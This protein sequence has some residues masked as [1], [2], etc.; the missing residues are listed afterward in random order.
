MPF[1]SENGYYNVFAFPRPK[2]VAFLIDPNNCSPEKLDAIIEFNIENYGG[3]YN[4]IIPVQDNKIKNNYWQLLK[5]SDPDIVYSYVKLDNQLIDKIDKEISPY[6]FLYHRKID[7]MANDNYTWHVDIDDLIKTMDVFSAMIKQKCADPFE[8]NTI[9]SFE[10]FENKNID[11]F[12]SRNFGVVKH[13]FLKAKVQEGNILKLCKDCSLSH[14]LK[15]I[16]EKRGI[17]T[18][19]QASGFEVNSNEPDYN[20]ENEYNYIII[21]D[22]IWSWLYYWNRIIYFPAWKR[23]HISQL[24]IPLN[25]FENSENKKILSDFITAK[26]WSA[27]SG[28]STIK[29]ISSVTDE[30]SLEIFAKEITKGHNVQYKVEK[31]D[32]NTF[33]VINMRKL[34]YDIL[35]SER[36]HLNGSKS[37]MQNTYPKNCNKESIVGSWMIDLKIEYRPELFSYINH[38]YW[39]KLPKHSGVTYSFVKQGGRITS[40]GLISI[41][42]G[43]DKKHIELQIPS[44]KSVFYS[45]LLK[46]RI[47]MFTNDIRQN[48]LKEERKTNNSKT[49]RISDKGA[50]TR[51]VMSIFPNLWM[52]KEFIG[53]RYWRK[54][55]FKMCQ[56]VEGDNRNIKPIL[57]KIDKYDSNIW[58]KLENKDNNAKIQ[59]AEYILKTSKEQQAVNAKI[60]FDDLLEY[61][62]KEREEFIKMVGNSGFDVT[63]ENNKIDLLNAVNELIE[64]SVFEQG[65]NI[66]CKYCG[67]TIWYGL[68]EFKKEVI[69]HGCQTS[70]MINAESK[71]IYKLNELIKNGIIFHGVMPVIWTLGELLQ[72][73]RDSFIYL[74][75]LK[76]YDGENKAPSMEIDIVCIKDG[77][78]VIGEVKTSVNNFSEKEIDKLVNICKEIRPN[79]VVV[80]AFKDPDKKINKI[81][82]N[83]EIKLKGFDIKVIAI[84][85]GNS[86]FSPSYHI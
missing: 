53:N 42:T 38:S 62:N 2:R 20:I 17:I 82:E 24:C 36:Y 79:E 35:Y 3:R 28:I 12:I 29:F 40:D 48:I 34:N 4:P 45:Y 56:I 63:K 61:F 46:D 60:S 22:D 37:V 6:Y 9:L 76:I 67:S 64:I 33:P 70:N 25:D 54:I 8:N 44:D 41:E 14:I 39:W 43:S 16:S 86:Y 68:E 49:I 57:E 15:L 84:I 71:W 59:L 26:F 47:V 77:K 75:S 69:C 1:N 30:N 31:I 65:V 7:D 80:S 51:G 72:F 32:D 66:N 58:K 83:V 5:I 85:P 81:R 52:L 23:K 73:S 78:L 13:Q 21:G 27:N 10:T 18:P 11:R 19:I 55:L 50:Y 74:P